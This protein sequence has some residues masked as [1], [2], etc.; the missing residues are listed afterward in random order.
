[1][2]SMATVA[3][4]GHVGLDVARR[5][6]TDPSFP[7]PLAQLHTGD[8]YD[9]LEVEKW[10]VGARLQG[11]GDP[12]GALSGAAV[13]RFQLS[14]MRGHCSSSSSSPNT[15]SSSASSLS[16]LSECRTQCSMAALAPR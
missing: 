8:L 10:A 3:E 15:Q 9:R 14:Q 13:R 5:W 16:A 1:M 12:G 11:V 4:M 2:I 7:K 6:T